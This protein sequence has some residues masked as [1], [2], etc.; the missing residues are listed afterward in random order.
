MKPDFI[1]FSYLVIFRI[2]NSIGTQQ[3]V[4]NI[5]HV[6]PQIGEIYTTNSGE[7]IPQLKDGIRITTAL[8]LFSTSF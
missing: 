2:L 8:W 7:A 6:Y 5:Y 4:G 3:F 1:N